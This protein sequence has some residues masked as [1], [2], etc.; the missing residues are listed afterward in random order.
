MSEV[1]II[2]YGV[3]NLLSVSRAVTHCGFEVM[4]S[5]DHRTILAARRVLL[6][7][8][9]AFA[10]GMSALREQGLDDV[11]RKVAASGTPLLGICLGMQMLVDSSEEFGFT[12]GL[13]LLPGRVIAIP[14]ND[15][16][17]DAQKV[18]HIG[19][20]EL[21]PNHG[22]TSWSG[23]ILDD[24]VP[25]DAVYFVHSFMTQ[26]S[27][28]E[29]SLAYCLYGGVQITAV[30]AAGNVWGCQFHPEKSGE[31]GLKVLQRFL[32]HKT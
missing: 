18:P 9:G 26:V 10:N 30:I 21:I 1:V 7:G 27:N 25:G 29:H 2:D 31:V 8:V 23:T 4:V 15:T 19:W 12:Q 16:E 28:P 20:N 17:G 13:G 22:K 11:L 3:G 5:C 14:A 6:P 24:L 32:V